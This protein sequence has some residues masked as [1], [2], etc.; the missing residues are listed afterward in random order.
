MRSKE[1]EII[2]L[3]LGP[4]GGGKGTQ[5]RFLADDFGFRVLTVSS[6]LRKIGDQ[7][8]KPIIKAMMARGQL[9]PAKIV[10]QA[11]ARALFKRSGRVLLD[12]FGR[13]LLELKALRR[14]IRPKKDLRFCLY[15]EVKREEIVGRL[16]ARRVCKTCLREVSQGAQNCRFCKKS[17]LIKR[18]DDQLAVVLKRLAI[19][20]KNSPPVLEYLEKES[21]LIRVNGQG[22]VQ[23]I[24]KRIALAL[25]K[26]GVEKS[27]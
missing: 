2:G 11:V 22:S 20:E 19:H 18:P 24:R 12:G 4:P 7:N 5:A 16:K 21:L 23:A 17:D 3:I 1:A 9:L 26:I 13:R 15:L 14:A 6:L 27:D 10:V 25:A 8:R